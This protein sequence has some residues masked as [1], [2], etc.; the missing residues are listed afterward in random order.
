MEAEILSEIRDSEKKAE[1]IIERA[2][3]E[4]ERILHEAR[5]NASKLFESKEEE[6]RKFQEKKLMES[7]EKYKSISEAKIA[8]GKIAA[9]QIKSKSEKNIPKS[10]DFI[11]KKFEEML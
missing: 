11:F 1:E 5:A 10:V 8:E 3:H 6:M 2:K 7:K 9:K 4:K